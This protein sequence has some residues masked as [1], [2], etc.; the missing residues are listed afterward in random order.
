MKNV[1]TATATAAALFAG[2]AAFA[3]GGYVDERG[4]INAQINV[5]DAAATLPYSNANST[6][7]TVQYKERGRVKN[8]SVTLFETDA[9]SIKSANQGR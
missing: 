1:L 7:T 5:Q 4:F 6:E 2:S 8:V 9:E 3:E